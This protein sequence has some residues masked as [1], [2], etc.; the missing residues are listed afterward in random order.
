MKKPRDGEYSY[1]DMAMDGTGPYVWIT[2]EGSYNPVNPSKARQIA[3]K[4]LDQAEYVEFK[5][6]KKNNRKSAA[7]H[8][9]TCEKESKE[10]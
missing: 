2:V 7:W 8:C 9:E 1:I 4:L 6:V 3:N 10:V 5:N